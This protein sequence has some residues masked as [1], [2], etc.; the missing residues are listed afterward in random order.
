MV[1]QVTGTSR[2][3]GFVTYSNPESA[4]AAIQSMNGFQ[5]GRKHL[6]VQ[7]KKDRWENA[8]TETVKPLIPVP[9][10]PYKSSARRRKNNSQQQQTQGSKQLLRSK[11]GLKKGETS[12]KKTEKLGEQQSG[13]NKEKQTNSGLKNS[14][15]NGIQTRKG[16]TPKKDKPVGHDKVSELANGIEAMYIFSEGTSPIMNSNDVKTSA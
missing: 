14:G 15:E 4:E 12:V 13:S 7:R 10:M 11:Q 1:D 9:A 16:K 8:M 5:I 6:K 3:F 2:G